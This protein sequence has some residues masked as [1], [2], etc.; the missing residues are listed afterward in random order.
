MKLF[1]INILF[2]LAWT[3]IS[4]AQTAD[5]VKYQSLDPYYF[6]LHLGLILVGLGC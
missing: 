4:G 6:H 2:I 1:T 3:G 5:S